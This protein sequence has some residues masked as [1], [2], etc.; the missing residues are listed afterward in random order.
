M[1]LRTIAWKNNGIKIIDQTKL[2]GELKYMQVKDLKTLWR[3][4]K[5]LKVRGAPALGAAAALGVYLGAKG[6]GAKNFGEF[7]R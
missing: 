6:S 7:S 4:I 2:P 5:E 3:A 1:D